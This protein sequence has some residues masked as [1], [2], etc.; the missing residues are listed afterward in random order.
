MTV[1]H[2]EIEEMKSGLRISV[3]KVL[4]LWERT[5]LGLLSGIVAFWMG[6]AFIGNWRWILA[7]LVALIA[8]ATAR[9]SR[10]Q[11]TVSNVELVTT[12][13]I[14]SRGSWSSRVVCTGDV[15]GLEFRDAG[16][17]RSGLYALTARSALC[18]LPFIDYADAM[19]AISAIR[20]RFPGL[21]EHWQAESGT[22]EHYLTLGLG[23]VK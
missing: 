22:S 13:N 5:A 11:L 21:T 14:G 10:A 1:A 7:I 4:P 6:H 20:A 8:L 9:G 16:P 2:Y 17:N 12:G 18:I 23:K 19:K 3:Q 15:R